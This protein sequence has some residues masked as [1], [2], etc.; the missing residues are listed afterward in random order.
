MLKFNR[1]GASRRYRRRSGKRKRHVGQRIRKP[2]PERRYDAS[3][4]KPT[5]NNH[6]PG[7]AGS[8]GQ[9]ER[10]GQSF[11]QHAGQ[12][13]AERVDARSDR[14][15]HSH[16]PITDKAYRTS[17]SP[18]RRARGFFDGDHRKAASCAKSR[19]VCLRRLDRLRQAPVLGAEHFRKRLPERDVDVSGSCSEAEIGQT[20][21]A[22]ARVGDA[23]GDDGGKM[24]QV[25]ID[26]D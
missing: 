17:K 2:V 13:V 25:G 10:A 4:G 11:R 14:N 19:F 16:R 26:V 22:I 9:S 23:A 18:A 7:E 8:D 6:G 5:G 24:G 3:G 1:N 21:D 12:P 15:W 20:R